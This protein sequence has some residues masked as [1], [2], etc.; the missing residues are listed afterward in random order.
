MGILT[1]G[2]PKTLKSKDKGYFPAILHLLPSTLG[3]R[4][5][6]KINLCPYASDGCKA[7]CLNT[8]GR[9]GILKP[10]EVT[11]VIQEA[12]R[13]RTHLFIDNKDEFFQLLIKDINS[14]IKRCKRL[15]LT[16]CFRLNG[17]SDLLWEKQGFDYEGKRYKNI[18]ELFPNIKFYD[19]TKRPNRYKI[20]SNYHLT[21]SLSESNEQLAKQSLSNGQNVAVVFKSLPNIFMDHKVINGDETDLRFLDPSPSIIGLKAKGKAK[22]DMSGFV[23]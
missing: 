2:N 7:A 5:N 19:Y 20:P 3:S 1:L 16:P 4:S 6:R 15:T 14:H 22:K 12:R 9:G 21:F 23:K 10:G 11:N 13:R 18:M 17:T 8:A